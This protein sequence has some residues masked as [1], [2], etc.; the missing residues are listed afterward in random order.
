MEAPPNLG[1][2]YTRQ[3]RRAYRDLARQYK[4]AL[5]PFLLEGDR[6][7]KPELNQADGIHPNVEGEKPL[8]ENVWR[9]SNPS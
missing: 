8:V 6:W 3:F 2:D 1:P 5:I 4:V 7:P 9:S